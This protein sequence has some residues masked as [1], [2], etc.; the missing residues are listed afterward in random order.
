MSIILQSDVDYE[1]VVGQLQA[2]ISDKILCVVNN[3]RLIVFDN[4]SNIP[5]TLKID[6]VTVNDL[7]GVTTYSYRDPD[8]DLHSFFVDIDKISTSSTR[9]KKSKLSIGQIISD[10][11]TNIVVEKPEQIIML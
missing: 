7:T 10:E 1:F 6:I 5:K 8:Q 11:V 4:V 3:E 9:K 2:L